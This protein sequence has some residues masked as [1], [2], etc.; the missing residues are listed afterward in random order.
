[1]SFVIIQLNSL[2]LSDKLDLDGSMEEQPDTQKLKLS[3]KA[4]KRKRF[5]EVCLCSY[6]TVL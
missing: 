1:M 4:A 2:A 3:R 6:V 5:S